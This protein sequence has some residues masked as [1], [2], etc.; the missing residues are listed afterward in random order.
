MKVRLGNKED[1]KIVADIYEASKAF[2]KANDNGSQWRDNYPIEED[3][4]DDIENNIGYVIEDENKN[5]VASFAFKIGEDPT[6]LEIEDGTWLDNSLYGTIHRLASYPEVTN[7]FDTCLEF[8]LSKINH[9]RADTHKNNKIMLHLLESRG[10]KR[11][12]IIT[13]INKTKRDAYELVKKEN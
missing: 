4:I 12:G 10:F 13:V 3:F 2:M 11:C 5:V 9:L 8:C 7:V 1:A 6:Y